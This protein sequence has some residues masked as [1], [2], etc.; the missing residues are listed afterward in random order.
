M[1]SVKKRHLRTERVISIVIAPDI[2]QVKKEAAGFKRE[3][4]SVRV[5]NNAALMTFV[6]KKLT[7]KHFIKARTLSLVLEL[8][9]L[10]KQYNVFV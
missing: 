1:C 5:W 7:L 4:N 8:I 2:F 6:C 10:S 9:F 3:P